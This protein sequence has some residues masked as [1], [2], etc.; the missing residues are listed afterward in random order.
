MKRLQR[1]EMM[2]Y[3]PLVKVKLHKGQVFDSDDE[4]CNAEDVFQLE[5]LLRECLPFVVQ[6]ASEF[7]KC[8]KTA[9]LE[10][11]VKEALG[12]ES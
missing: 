11:R 8:S 10:R 7:P 5:E 9:S 12:E 1:Y 2:G 3:A 6:M 4:W